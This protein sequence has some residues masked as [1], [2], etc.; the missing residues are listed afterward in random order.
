MGRGQSLQHLLS[1]TVYFVYSDVMRFVEA[2][3]GSNF[4]VE[5]VFSA[6]NWISLVS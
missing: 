4:P 2:V 1:I 6:V 3:N 5:T